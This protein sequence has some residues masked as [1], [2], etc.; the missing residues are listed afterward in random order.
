MRSSTAFHLAA[1][2][3]VCQSPA[4]REDARL[5]STG[6][7]GEKAWCR[8][9]SERSRLRLVG[10]ASGQTARC[11]WTQHCPPLRAHSSQKLSNLR[12][13]RQKDVARAQSQSHSH[14]H[15]KHKVT[16]R[17]HLFWC[18]PPVVNIGAW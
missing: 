10:L 11:W 7:G 15:I 2:R 13:E 17:R 1:C 16:Q 4:Q 9:A 18:E 5:G 8:R 12:R 6:N 14:T 3:L